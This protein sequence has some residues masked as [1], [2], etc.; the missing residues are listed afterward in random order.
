MP[1]TPWMV[2]AKPNFRQDCTF[3]KPLS[4]QVEPRQMYCERL[5]ETA[6]CGGAYKN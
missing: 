5:T 2:R 3:T 1:H 6:V 4:T